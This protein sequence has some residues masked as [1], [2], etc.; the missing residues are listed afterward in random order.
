MPELS[1]NSPMLLRTLSNI[2]GFTTAFAVLHLV[3]LTIKDAASMEA[4][5]LN[6]HVGIKGSWAFT[7]NC[8]RIKYSST[9]SLAASD[10]CALTALLKG[11]VTQCIFPIDGP[12]DR[13]PGD[14]RF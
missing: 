7:V 4:T 14:A 9:G 5:I 10:A 1:F 3:T 2:N 6:S 12:G 8:S 11:P 13:T